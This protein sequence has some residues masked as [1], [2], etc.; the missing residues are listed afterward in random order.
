M[1]EQQYACFQVSLSIAQISTPPE[2]PEE[3]GR[4]TI[5]ESP[6]QPHEHP[7]SHIAKGGNYRS[8]P[9]AASFVVLYPECIWNV[10][11]P[12]EALTLPQG[13]HRNRAGVLRK[14]GKS[15][16][17][18]LGQRLNCKV[19]PRHHPSGAWPSLQIKGDPGPSLMDNPQGEEHRSLAE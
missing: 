13:C 6:Q 14:T 17:K 19:L 11:I 12:Q 2:V 1:W 9:T 7:W 3:A 18:N 15:H 4:P 8:R 5:K 16:G 10:A